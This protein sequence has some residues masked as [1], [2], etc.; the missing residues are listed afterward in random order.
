[1]AL[2]DRDRPLNKRG[3]KASSLIGKRLSEEGFTVDHVV[4]STAQRAVQTLER[5]TAA[6]GFDWPVDYSSCLYGAGAN[7]LLSVIHQQDDSLESILLV[8]HNP[9][10]EELAL[11]LSISGDPGLFKKVRKKVPTGSLIS[12][13]FNHDS[14]SQIGVGTGRLVN[15]MRPKHEFLQPA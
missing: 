12:L 4:C 13:E 1:M 6:G 8:G 9:G 5:V 7:R 10:L 15:F 11:A 3:E 14:F 2:A